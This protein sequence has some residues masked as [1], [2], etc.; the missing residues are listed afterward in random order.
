VDGRIHELPH[1]SLQ[2][3]FGEGDA[4]RRRAAH[5]LMNNAVNAGNLNNLS[6][7]GRQNDVKSLRVR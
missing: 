4:T 6:G 3:V 2:E 1:R 5:V 7:Y